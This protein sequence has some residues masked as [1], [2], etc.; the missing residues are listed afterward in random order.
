MDKLLLYPKVVIYREKQ[1]KAQTCWHFPRCKVQM[2]GSMNS[3][4]GHILYNL[5]LLSIKQKC[6]VE[7]LW[8]LSHQRK[9]LICPAIKTGCKWDDVKLRQARSS[10]LTIDILNR[11]PLL[12]AER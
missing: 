2:D 9:G 12:L 5:A 1:K 6:H 11:A 4:C 3:L 8:V 7:I 10:H